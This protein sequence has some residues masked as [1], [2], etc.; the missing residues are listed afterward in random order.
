MFWKK[1]D[2][3]NII[4]DVS[5]E[6]LEEFLTENHIYLNLDGCA[7]RWAAFSNYY[8]RKHGLN[9]FESASFSS[10][11]STFMAGMGVSA[12]TEAYFNEE[13]IEGKVIGLYNRLPEDAD[14][15]SR[16]RMLFRQVFDLYKNDI[17]KY[18]LKNRRIEV[19]VSEREYQKFIGLPGDSKSKKFRKLLNK[20]I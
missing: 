15:I 14:E 9:P 7:E 3:Y 4:E 20:A 12:G 5:V 6:E 18:E 10:I 8:G 13:A 2:E 11:I 17:A 1:E 19:R 16:K